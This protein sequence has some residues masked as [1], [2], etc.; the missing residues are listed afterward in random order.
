MIPS[1]ATLDE[2]A[3]KAGP[4]VDWRQVLLALADLKPEMMHV[5]IKP[6]FR[7]EA[8]DIDGNWGPVDPVLFPRVFRIGGRIH[9]MTPDGVSANP[10]RTRAEWVLQQM[11]LADT[12]D[13]PILTM[14]GL[15][16]LT[17][18]YEL[19]TV[20]R[21]SPSQIRF[22]YEEAQQILERLGHDSP[23]E[24]PVTARQSTR[25][26]GTDVAAALKKI[27]TAAKEAGKPFDREKWPGTAQE[28]RAALEF[29]SP[30]IAYT[31]PVHDDNFK[32]LVHEFGLKF[33]H[34]GRSRTKGLNF[35]RSIFP[36]YPA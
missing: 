10:D 36:D 5:I 31:L 11:M 6:G 9:T 23:S 28:L 26:R 15:A 34:P 32:G 24:K 12:P 3:A 18:G 30:G 20:D 14:G 4:G 22:T 27:E 35:Y 1:W 21:L 16:D 29:V 33:A 17:W 25:A 7:C 2:L 19:R 8:E 13:E